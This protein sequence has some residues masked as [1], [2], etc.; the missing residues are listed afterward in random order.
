M[1]EAGWS[2]HGC[3]G[4]ASLPLR[5]PDFNPRPHLVRFMI[6]QV[7]VGE[8]FLQVHGFVAVSVIP[9]VA[10]SHSFIYHSRYIKLSY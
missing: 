8:G 5:R 7:A 6:D 1:H 4:V 9:V 3:G 2:C 10:L